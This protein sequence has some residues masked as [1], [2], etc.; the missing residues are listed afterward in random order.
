MP[1]YEYRTT[2]KGCDYCRDSFEVRQS[3]GSKPFTKCPRCHS[4]V[5]RLISQF[6]AC[7]IET[8]DEAIAT[9][10]KIREYEKE[11]RWSHAAELADKAGLEDRAKENYKKAGYNM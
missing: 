9:E 5:R 1:I 7:V 2:E 8:A 6:R 3:M 10:R 11:G 4:P